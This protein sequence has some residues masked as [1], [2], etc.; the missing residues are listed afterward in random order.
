MASYCVAQSR[1]YTRFKVFNNRHN[2]PDSTLSDSE[3]KSRIEDYL[4]QFGLPG[5]QEQQQDLEFEIEDRI[6]RQHD[7]ALNRWFK[8]GK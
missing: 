2:I 8:G 1:E 5:T 4:S 7:H 3:N 6:R